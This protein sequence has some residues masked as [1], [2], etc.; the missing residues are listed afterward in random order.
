MKIRVLLSLLVFCIPAILFSQN[1]FYGLTPAGGIN[2]GG[3]VIKYESNSNILSSV[4]SF[5]NDPKY[6]AT[7]GTPVQATNGKLYGMTSQGGAGFGTI[8]SLDPAANAQVQLFSFSHTNGALP[9]GSLIQA[10]DGKLYGLTLN[11]GNGSSDMGTI[12]SFDPA[13][14]IFVKLAD[15]TGANGANPYGSLVQA[16]NGKLYGMTLQGGSNGLGTIFSFNP[17]TNNIDHLVDFIDAN[18]ASPFGDLI[19]AGN[20]KLYGMTV[21]GGNEGSGII[22]SFDP[23]TNSLEKLYD[24]FN[25]SNAFPHGSLVKASNGKLYGMTTNGSAANNFAGTIFSFDPSTN[26][27][28]QLFDF[29][30]DNGSNPFGNLVEAANGKLYGMTSQGGGNNLGT[31]FSFD[32]SANSL[33]K[34]LDF[35]GINGSNPYGSLVKASNGKLYGMTR[36]G[37]VT[38]SGMIFSFD[39]SGNNQT[40]L[41]SFN[42]TNT[43]STSPSG[44]LVKATDGKLY[45]LT[46]NGGISDKG[47]IFSF[48]PGTNAQV[49]LFDFN[50]INGANPFGGS[51]LDAGNGKLYGITNFGGSN[52][53]GTIFSFEPIS[54]IQAK[55]FDFNG[56][57]GESPNGILVKAKDGKL[58]GTSQGGG[59]SGYGT[60]FSFDP[61]NNTQTKLFDFNAS[62]GIFPSAGLIQASNGLLYGTTPYSGNNIGSGTIYSFDP[63]TNIHKQVFEF[64]GT[65]GANPYGSLMQASNG[66]LYGMALLGGNSYTG[67]L[68]SFDPS[69]NTYLKLSDFVESTGTY[70]GGMLVEGIGGKLYGMN[71]TGGSGNLGALFSYDI[72][73]GILTNLQDFNG[74]NGASPLWGSSL[75]QVTTNIPPNV[76]ITSP[77]NPSTFNAGDIIKIKANAVD[78]DGS[79]AKTELFISGSLYATDNT[80]PYE[81]SYL[82]AEPGMY[83]ATVKATD[84][85]GSS[86]ISDTTVITVIGCKG[87]GSITVE[88]F[89]NI[90]GS[91]ISDLTSNPAYPNKPKITC[92]LK[93][94]EYA[95]VGN[96]YGARVRGYICTP[97]TGNY[98][99][100]ISG[101]DQAELYLSKD[102]N[103]ANKVLIAYAYS[104]TKFREW[105]KF[106]SQKS[107]PIFLVKGATYYIEAL[108]KEATCT[109]HLSVAWK[110]PDYA[111]E[112]PIPGSRLSPYFTTTKSEAGK[113]LELKTFAEEMENEDDLTVTVLPNPSSTFFTLQIYGINDKPV[114]V[115]VMDVAGRVLESKQTTAPNS[116]MQVGSKLPAGIYFV[117]IQ[118]GTQKER[119]KLV[120]Q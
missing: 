22:F 118:Q 110:I 46:S 14:D 44:S 92:S 18:G 36:T 104:L 82:N 67:T 76:S 24:F 71:S 98:T 103:P 38:G 63:L 100:N 88:G 26:V 80:A 87:S 11:G 40:N 8:F 102:K 6:P 23:S 91:Q 51:L 50:E 109:D 60:I 56:A 66:K 3:T 9:T 93:I 70:P 94:F 89:T 61:L 65:D 12:F 7:Y 4:F 90:K 21:Q 16:S 35:T 84:N 116:T 43:N 96:N 62:T 74:T 85:T 79:I 68:F 81:F 29:T 59:I 114:F 33:A 78:A 106:P 120:K 86:S 13:T 75:L 15:F 73:T 69:T 28:M 112:G 95:N 119:L 39:L 27:Q 58:Y 111:F 17:A 41:Y 5:P 45:G 72:N 113:T 42:T 54:N 37:G 117:E 34:L 57:N 32:V 1:T 19:E 99:F 101:D 31:I 10:T 105:N 20:G 53:Y 49:K 47:T 52:S 108:H 2:G 115:I 55:L 107:K 30:G 48:D 83:K 97:V 25:I 64:N 77:A